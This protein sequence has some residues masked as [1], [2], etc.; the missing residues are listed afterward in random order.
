MVEHVLLCFEVHQPKRLA[1]T[2]V[3]DKSVSFWSEEDRRILDRV[4]KRCYTQANKLLYETQELK[5]GLSISGVLL[6]QLMEQARWDVIEGFRKLFSTGRFE[7]I[8]ETYYHSLASL[9]D[10]SELFEQVGMQRELIKRLFDTTPTCFT[11][12]ELILSRSVAKKVRELGFKATF[13][14]GCAALLG[15]KSPNEVYTVD[16]VKV[17]TRNNSLSDDIGFRFSDRS[18]SEYPLSAEKWAR[19]ISKSQGSLLTVYIDYET[20]GEHHDASSGIFEFLARVGK[21]LNANGVELLTPSEAACLESKDSLLAESFTSWADVEK[22]LSAWL[23]NSIQKH[24]FQEI[25]SLE[26]AVKNQADPEILRTWRVL[27]ESDHLYYCSTK[28]AASGEVHLYFNPYKS[29]YI[30]Y[31]N[32]VNAV[33]I[34]ARELGF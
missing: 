33:S 5:A 20:F 21:E 14:E 10:T 31:I 34:I 23:G 12:T 27:T 13:A 2:R 24:A 4:S 15:N 11:N 30:A 25:Y 32:L 8:A 26:E 29:P 18:W 28:K 19:W 1:R 17:F 22:D 3:F 7:P 9:V 16:G 6:E